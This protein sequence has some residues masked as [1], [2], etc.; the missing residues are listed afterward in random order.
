[1]SS[2]IYKQLFSHTLIYGKTSI[3]SLVEVQVQQRRVNHTIT[4]LSVLVFQCD[5]NVTLLT[6]DVFQAC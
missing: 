3:S 1:M 2:N 4:L 6:N 5:E